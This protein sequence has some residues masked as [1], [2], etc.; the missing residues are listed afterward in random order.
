MKLA[1]AILLTLSTSAFAQKKAIIDFED[2]LIEGSVNK[3]DIALILEQK[4]KNFGRLVKLR[5]NF[6]SEMKKTGSN[7]RASKK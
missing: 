2:E 5:Q 7:V 1:L 3:P 6:L 4:G